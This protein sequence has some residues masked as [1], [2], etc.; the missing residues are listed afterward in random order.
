VALV[1]ILRFLLANQ[2]NGVNQERT[3]ALS[4]QWP[5]NYLSFENYF[6]ILSF[7]RAHTLEWPAVWLWQSGFSLE[8]CSIR[9]M[10]TGGLCPFQSA[11]PMY[12]TRPRQ[13]WTMTLEYIIPSRIITC[14]FKEIELKLRWII[15]LLTYFGEIKGVFDAMLCHFSYSTPLAT[16]YSTSYLWCCAIG[17]AV[18]M[19]TGTL[20]SLVLGKWCH[21]V[22]IKGWART[23]C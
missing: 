18:T 11:P 6:Y 15:Q 21:V 8:P 19:V 9:Q 5:F 16:F 14:K 1:I 3:C 2:K 10:I 4:W 20:T 13:L 22:E 17:W 23:S 12:S 7:S